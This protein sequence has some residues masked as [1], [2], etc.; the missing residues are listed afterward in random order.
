M[1]NRNLI[2]RLILF[3]LIVLVPVAVSLPSLSEETKVM[4]ICLFILLIILMG[5]T[6]GLLYIKN[7]IDKLNDKHG[8]YR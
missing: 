6:N 1:K 2:F 7:K 3:D 4:G 8:I 5:M